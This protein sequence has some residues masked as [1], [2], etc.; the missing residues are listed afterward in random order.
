MQACKELIE[1]S[2]LNH[3]KDLKRGTLRYLDNDN[4]LNAIINEVQEV[5][6]EIKEHNIPKL[7]DELCDIL[8]GWMM[9]VENLKDVGLTRSHEQIL[10]R[11]L[12]KYK[13]RII[14]LVGE[15]KKDEAIWQ[16]V[17]SE[18]K[19][20]LEQEQNLLQFRQAVRE[21]YSHYYKDGDLAHQIDHADYVCNLALQLNQECDPK[22]IILAA[23]IHDIFNATD[24]KNHHTL[25]YNYVLESNNKFLKELSEQE[26]KLVAHA[27][28]E[29]R[30]SFKGEFYSKLSEIISSADRGTPDIKRVVIRSMQFNNGDAKSVYKHIKSKYGTN[31]YAKYPQSYQEIFS[32]ELQEFQKI[33]DNITIADIEQIWREC[34]K[35]YLHPTFS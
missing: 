2:K 25:A 33:V 15:P 18:Q 28:L 21:F 5:K 7:E 4:L 23:Y 20:A 8:W 31:G 9:L 34:H 10:Q 16:R 1:L 32:K 27:V 19:V 30:A 3:Q 35:S 17:K 12:K 24:R 14:P 29:H 6:E 11:A 22:L 26:R 13:E